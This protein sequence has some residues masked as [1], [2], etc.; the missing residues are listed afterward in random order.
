MSNRV[1]TTATRQDG[2]HWVILGQ[3]PPAIAYRGRGEWAEA[4]PPRMI[5]W[6]SARAWLPVAGA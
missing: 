6:C 1:S 2:H 5:G 4:R 3:D